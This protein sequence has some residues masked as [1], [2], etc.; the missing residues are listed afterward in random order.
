M[1]GVETT[2]IASGA[3]AFGLAEPGCNLQGIVHS[4]YHASHHNISSRLRGAEL[5]SSTD[6]GRYPS[7]VRL[8]AKVMKLAWLPAQC[9]LKVTGGSCLIS[10]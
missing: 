3:K 7:P 9:P 2:C 8:L 6:I 5:V 4:S 10:G 1:V